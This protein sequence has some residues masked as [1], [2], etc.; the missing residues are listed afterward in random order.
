MKKYLLVAGFILAAIFTLSGCSNEP[1]Q[2]EIEKIVR[3]ETAKAN[4]Q[5][6]NAFGGAGKALNDMLGGAFKAELTVH[7][8][9][10]LGCEKAEQGGYLCDVEVESDAPFIGRK[11]EVSAVRFVETDDGWAAVKE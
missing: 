6:Q 8:V 1:S 2:E 3:E 7:S 10:K 9:K 11:K 4:A 5:M